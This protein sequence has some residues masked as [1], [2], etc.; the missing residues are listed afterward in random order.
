MKKQLYIVSKIFLLP[1]G[2]FSTILHLCLACCRLSHFP[3]FSEKKKM[4]TSKG[5]FFSPVGLWNRNT[6]FMCLKR[7]EFNL[8]EPWCIIVGLEN[9]KAI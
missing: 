1:A 9:E 2:T 7:L 5:I 8:K 6:F 4:N 3:H